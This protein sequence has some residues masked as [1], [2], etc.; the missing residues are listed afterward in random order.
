MSGR[1]PLRAGLKRFAAAPDGAAAVEFAMVVGPFLFMIF[2]VL[3]LALVSLVSSSL[4]TA[5]ERA[6]RRIRTGQVQTANEGQTT[7][8]KTV[9][10]GMTWLASN[11]ETA[12]RVDVRTFVQFPD[13]NVIPGPIVPCPDDPAK[14]CIAK[15]SDLFWDHGGPTDVVVVRAYYQWPLITPFLSNALSRLDGNVA[16]VQS[17][18]TFRN[19]PYA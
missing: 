15:D 1:S 2:A 19:E 18:H 17:T 5:A 4:D 13:S 3:E 16:V 7:F 11:C 6:A 12:L 9:C 10:E 14:K 8:K